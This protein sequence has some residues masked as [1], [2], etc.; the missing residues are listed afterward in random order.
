MRTTITKYMLDRSDPEYFEKA[1][2]LDKLIMFD[3]QLVFDTYISSLVDEVQVAKDTLETYA[4][5]LEEKV[6]S[7]TAQLKELSVRDRL[8]NL[9]NRRGLYE[10]L[11][12]ELAVAKRSLHPVSLIYM[13]LNNFKKL[14]DHSGHDAGDTILQMV[15][16]A[17]ESGIRDIDHGFRHGG[18]EFSILL[19]NTLVD[20]AKQVY[21][22]IIREFDKGDTMGVTFSAGII[23]SDPAIPPERADL[24]KKADALMYEAKTLAHKD[25]QHHIET[26]V[27]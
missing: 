22:R 19:P 3:M 2:A 5:S 1:S 9:Y 23:Q 8:T 21:M 7:R 12:H 4:K 11:R 16:A 20:A 6:S 26:G 18:D 13:D 10:I 25:N 24:L 17:I 27:C 15:G 14:N